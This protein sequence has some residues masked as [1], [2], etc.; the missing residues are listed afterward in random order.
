MKP[1]VIRKIFFI[2]KKINTTYN[3][4]DIT[5]VHLLLVLVYS[6]AIFCEL[7]RI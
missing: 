5:Q 3:K 1:P 6:D 2:D 7:V 4:R